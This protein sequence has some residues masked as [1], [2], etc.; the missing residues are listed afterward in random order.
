MRYIGLQEQI[1]TNKVKSVIV[2]ILYPII[3]AIS[4]WCV[5]W[6]VG[7]LFEYEAGIEIV[8]GVIL[9]FLLWYFIAYLIHSSIIKSVTGSSILQR[10]QNP[11]VY[12]IIENLSIASGMLMP[13]VNI[14]RVN[15]FNA[16]ASGIDNKTYTITLTEGLINYLNTEELEGVVAHELSHIKNKD[17]NLSMYSI[18]FAGFFNYIA[19]TVG[20]VFV[21][22]AKSDEQVKILGNENRPGLLGIVA[23]IIMP[24]FLI[25]AI[26]TLITKI[27]SF[28]LSRKREYL[29][30]ANA[31][32]IT[33]NPKALASALRKISGNPFIEQ[34]KNKSFA[35]LFIEKPFEK[36]GFTFF[37]LFNTHPSIEKRIKILEQM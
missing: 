21:F 15:T 5:F 18:I 2:L 9:F 29:A 20:V 1:T 27:M 30:D 8:L 11:R 3:T 16:F 7:Y 25:L 24:F 17:V 32:E 14:I 4:F 26:T 35:P 28:L 23:L 19:L 12:N 37:G 10:N 33:K 22:F 31:V 34:M 6:L 13:K 36:E